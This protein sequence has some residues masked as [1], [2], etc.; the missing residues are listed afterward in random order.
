MT[1][2]SVWLE[3]G[4]L[5]DYEGEVYARDVKNEDVERICKLYGLTFKG[6]TE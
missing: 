4:C 3:D 2:I 6:E 5:V 1:N